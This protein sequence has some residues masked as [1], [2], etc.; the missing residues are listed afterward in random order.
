MDEWFNGLGTPQKMSLRMLLGA[1]LSFLFLVHPT[2]SFAADAVSNS[3]IS[4][5]EKSGE[6]EKV[7]LS[8][9]AKVQVGDKTYE[10][11]NIGSGLRAKKVVFVHVKVYV[12]QLFSSSPKTF[13]KTKNSGLDSL[14]NQE[15]IAIRLQFLRGVDAKTIKNS[16]V[17]AFESN[18]VSIKEK[19]IADFLAAVER[20]GA[21]KDGQ[22]LSLV[23]VHLPEK[24]ETVYYE[25]TNGE[26]SAITGR[27]GFIREVFSIW[28]GKPSDSGVAKL[29]EELLKP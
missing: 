8:E 14:G 26:V 18:G 13:D 9:T 1:I 15:A 28:L 19:Q 29:K 5:K 17:E 2:P 25:G 27:E 3:L 4:L 22:A 11:S 20:G 23:G 6:L 7:V 16:F 12:A 24:V 10:L 21:V